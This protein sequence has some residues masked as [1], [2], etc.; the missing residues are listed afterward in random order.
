MT[1]IIETIYKHSI[2]DYKTKICIIDKNV[3][4]SYT[5]F[6]NKVLRM[7]Y[8]LKQIGIRKDDSVIVENTQ[9]STF[10]IIEFALHILNAVFV[11]LEM[12]PIEEKVDRVGKLCHAKLIIAENTEYSSDSLLRESETAKELP[13]Y[14]FPASNSVSEILFTTGTTG[15]EK[16]V[17]LTHASSIALAQNIIAGVSLQEDNVE[18]VPSPLNHSHG[19]RTCYANFYAGATVVLQ[20]NLVNLKSLFMAIEKNVVNSMDLV[21]SA[22]SFILK[23]TKDQIGKYKNQFRYI[24]F[25]SAPLLDSDKEQIIRLLPN[26]RM[27]NFYGSTESGRTVVYDFSCEKQKKNC[28]GKPVPNVLISVLDENYYEIT[29]SKERTGVLASSGP[30]NMICYLNDEDSTL[31]VLKDGMFVT[32]DEVYIDEDG[33]VILIGRK[34]DIINSGGY[35]ISPLDIE[36]KVLEINGIV[37][38]ICISEPHNTLGTVP[39]VLVVKDLGS[40][41]TKAELLKELRDKVELFML[42]QRIEFV[43][44]IQRTYNGKLNRKYYRNYFTG[45]IK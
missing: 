33:D 19:L 35:K 16:G 43:D 41:I 45:E 30:M 13:E 23:N 24:Q 39:A 32:N 38:A 44:S 28:I 1:S 26:T 42:P 37:D 18:I 31:Q 5:E 7:A 2:S 25:G 4:F 11:P 15:K 10:F 6:Y 36:A 20:K 12:N 9:D 29:S 8:L 17:V 22:L 34:D 21:P 27:Y 40:K 14:S 3:R